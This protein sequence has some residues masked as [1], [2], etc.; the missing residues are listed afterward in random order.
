M[1]PDNKISGFFLPVRC[2]NVFTALHHVCKKCI[3]TNVISH[4]LSQLIF[5]RVSTRRHTYYRFIQTLKSQRS[6]LFLASHQVWS[7]SRWRCCT[8]LTVSVVT[9]IQRLLKGLSSE[10]LSFFSFFSLSSALRHDE[11]AVDRNVSS[12]SS[13]TNAS[14]IKCQRDSLCSDNSLKTLHCF[15]MTWFSQ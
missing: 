12:L 3:S 7:V 11:P 15:Y 6:H 14:V 5:D 4:L 8:G 1:V 9:V 13:S 10:G 2:S